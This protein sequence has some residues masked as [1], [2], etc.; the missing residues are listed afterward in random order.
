MLFKYIVKDKTGRKIVAQKE[1]NSQEELIK[2]LQ[3]QGYYVIKILPVKIEKVAIGRKRRFTHSRITS[4]ELILLARQLATMLGAGVTLIKS[5]DIILPQIT[6][7]KLYSVVLD[8]KKRI[9][10]G[11]SFSEALKA[12]Q[13]VFSNLWISIVQTGETS[14]ELPIVLERLATYLEER[15]DFKRRIITA[16]TYPSLLF[17]IGIGALLFFVSR[18][19]PTFA[20]IFSQFDIKLPLPTRILISVSNF[21]VRFKWLII[22]GVP[23]GI[24]LIYKY[25]KGPGKPLFDRVIL[26]VPLFGVLFQEIFLERFSSEMKTLLE[27]GVSIVVSLKVTEDSIDN[28]IFKKA[29]DRIRES[30]KNGKPLSEEMRKDEVFSAMV[31]QLVSVGEEI[32]NLPEMFRR[33]NQFYS[34]VIKAKIE[35]MLALFEPFMIV[36]M[37][38]IIGSMVISMYLPIFKIATLAGK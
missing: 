1:A 2:L 32:G 13:N 5:L 30:V 18:I 29:I 10:E 27:A 36:I 6:S 19:V 37:G 31:T 34:N 7:K 28:I 8:I 25:I 4:G 12:H 15:G 22:L 21:I 35:R 11:S 23:S 38:I 16:L 3:A 26:R 24:F 33:I 17:L 20:E 14:G 9:E